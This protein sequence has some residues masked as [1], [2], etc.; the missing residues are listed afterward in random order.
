MGRYLTITSSNTSRGGVR[1]QTLPKKIR[2][3]PVTLTIITLILVC[4]LSLFYLAQLFDS[5]TKGYQMHDLE[6]KV[7]ELRDANTKLQVEAAGLK[8]YKNIEEEAR[9]LNMS[10]STS[11][12]YISRVGG[13]VVVAR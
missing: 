12:V 10:S 4:L 11:V 13:T 5:S 3:G 6:K 8:S 7:E 9:K 1:K 2:T